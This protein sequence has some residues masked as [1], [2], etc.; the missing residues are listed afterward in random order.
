VIF[1]D[2]RDLLLSEGFVLNSKVYYFTIYVR[3]ISRI[4]D[5]VQQEMQ[6]SLKM[7]AEVLIGGERAM[8]ESM[9]F[10]FRLAWTA[11]TRLPALLLLGVGLF[12]SRLIVE[13]NRN[14]GPNIERRLERAPIEN[15]NT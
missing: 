6:R 1:R 3:V 5:F 10:M 15:A 12:D 4:M 7:L 13:M 14:L 2:G 11:S 8:S 9:G